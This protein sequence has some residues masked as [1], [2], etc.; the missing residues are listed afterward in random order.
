MQN[1]ISKYRYYIIGAI[2]GGIA[3]LLYWRFVGCASGSCP[4]TSKWY[5]S[6]IYGMFMGILL[7]SSAPVKKNNQKPINQEER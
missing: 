2:L 4:I 7:G 1:F 6:T 3:G 5:N